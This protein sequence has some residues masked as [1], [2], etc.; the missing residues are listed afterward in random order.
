MN[1]AIFMSISMIS[2]FIKS[3][4]KSLGFYEYSVDL[5]SREHCHLLESMVFEE[6]NGVYKDRWEDV[7]LTSSHYYLLD[8]RILDE[9]RW[10]SWIWTMRYFFIKALKCLWFIF[11]LLRILLALY[12]PYYCYVRTTGNRDSNLV[13]FLHTNNAVRNDVLNRNQKLLQHDFLISKQ[14]ADSSGPVGSCRLNIS[15]VLDCLRLKFKFHYCT[16][17]AIFE[18]LVGRQLFSQ[19]MNKIIDYS[20]YNVAFS[21]EAWTPLSRV[22]L[23][24]ASVN[25]MRSVVFY[26]RAVVHEYMYVP[27]K[28]DTLLLLSE[29]SLP[30]YPYEAQMLYL[31]D[32]PFLPWRK[33]ATSSADSNTVGLLLGDEYNRWADQENHD[34]KI[35]EALSAIE[36]ITCLGR[37]HPQ[38]MT[39]PHRV[40][41]YKKL[42]ANYPFLKLEVADP[43]I[44]L[45]SI[46]LLITYAKSSMVEEALM[47]KRPVIECVESSSFSPNFAA[48]QRSSGLGVTC[49]Q[50]V[51]LKALLSKFE[52]ISD[53]S[54]RIMWENFVSRLGFSEAGAGDTGRAI[55]TYFSQ[56]PLT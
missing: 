9:M 23:D 20:N 14:A 26:T 42:C 40:Q 19:A 33:I 3:R 45:T 39:R 51:E 36:G 41:Y 54:L 8:K 55:E 34:H 21:R 17:D 37:P 52:R 43:E 1:G 38:E 28:V 15:V 2:G 11:D 16:S 46:S 6:L 24:A 4:T 10:H 32:N 29:K 31:A 53:D 50:V 12:R 7:F 5:P 44:F 25:R 13:I 22:F 35:L 47:C 30:K 49:S 27:R 48:I 18:V 56:R